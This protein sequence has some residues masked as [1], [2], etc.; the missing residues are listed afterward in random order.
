VDTL[1]PKNIRKKLKHLV[2]IIY[3][4]IERDGNIMRVMMTRIIITTIQ[5]S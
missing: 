2:T 4:R 5:V 1:C 3:S